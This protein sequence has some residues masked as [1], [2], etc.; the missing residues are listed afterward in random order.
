MTGRYEV[1]ASRLII[2]HMYMLSRSRKQAKVAWVAIGS[3]GTLLHIAAPWL[4][5]HGCAGA[6]AS[7]AVSGLLLLVSYLVMSAVPLWEMWRH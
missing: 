4:V 3:F 6:V 1:V 7:Y 2:S 5:A